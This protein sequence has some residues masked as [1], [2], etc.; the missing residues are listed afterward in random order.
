MY[1]FCQICSNIKYIQDNK[2]WDRRCKLGAFAGHVL[3]K[4]SIAVYQL[5]NVKND[6]DLSSSGNTTNPTRAIICDF[7][8]RRLFA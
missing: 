6:L 3:V 7:Y 1:L 8:E 4:T 5:G 2:L